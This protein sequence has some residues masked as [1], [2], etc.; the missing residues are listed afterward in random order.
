MCCNSRCEYVRGS[1][2]CNKYLDR[3]SKS[4]SIPEP[5]T[6]ETCT[7]NDS[8]SPTPPRLWLC[9]AASSWVVSDW[10][11]VVL[12]L[13]AY[14]VRHWPPRVYQRE[15]SQLQACHRGNT[16]FSGACYRVC[17]VWYRS[18]LITLKHIKQSVESTDSDL[19]DGI[20]SSKQNLPDQ[21]YLKML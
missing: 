9:L 13:R 8:N 14:W 10:W 2:V 1:T 11:V 5:E 4:R 17:S 15:P 19:Q 12:S 16:A 3:G 7:R 20:T 18:H 21:E 6:L